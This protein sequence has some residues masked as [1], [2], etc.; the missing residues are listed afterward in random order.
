MTTTTTITTKNNIPN[1]AFLVILI[2]NKV[3]RFSDGS[4]GVTDFDD[5]TLLDISPA[6]EVLFDEIFTVF[7]LSK[8]ALKSSR[9]FGF[10]VQQLAINFFIALGTSADIGNLSPSLIESLTSS[11]ET[12][13]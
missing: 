4:N 3:T 7:K 9:C 2:P 11:T 12:P 5:N 1:K 6:V 8:T 10:G 13:L